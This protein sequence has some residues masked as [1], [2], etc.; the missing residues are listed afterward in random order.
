ME[1]S[2]S[3]PSL[4]STNNPATVIPNS[5]TDAS[6]GNWTNWGLSVVSN[7]AGALIKEDISVVQSPIENSSS[8]NNDR[9][10]SGLKAASFSN[11]MER[12]STGLKSAT[13]D[14]PSSGLKTAINDKPSSGLKTSIN[15]KPSSGLK[16][17]IQAPPASQFKSE[18]LKSGWDDWDIDS[19]EETSELKN[20]LSVTV[21]KETSGWGTEWDDQEPI[22]VNTKSAPLEHTKFDE[23]GKSKNEMKVDK[24]SDWGNDD[25]GNEDWSAKPKKRNPLKK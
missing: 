11:N 17:T 5:N 12:P 14:R 9:P 22:S 19:V 18:P 6:G 20:R 24:T 4:P 15:D 3:V 8:G 13:N 23:R 16:S 21:I 7:V 10:S 1:R 2:K 25:W